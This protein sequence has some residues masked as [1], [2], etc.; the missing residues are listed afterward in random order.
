MDPVLGWMAGNQMVALNFQT[1]DWPM[2]LNTGL[3]LENGNT[4]YVLKPGYMV[5]PSKSPSPAV[6]IRVHVI[7]GQQLPKPGGET[8]GEVKRVLCF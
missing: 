3:F 2:F 6:G 1:P 5:D 4:G 7:S 8:L